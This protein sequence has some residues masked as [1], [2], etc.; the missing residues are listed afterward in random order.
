MIVFLG[1]V[2]LI[3]NELSSQYKPKY[4]Y[5]FN[6]EYVIGKKENYIPAKNKINL[7]HENSDFERIFGTNPIAV[8]VVN[9]HIFDYA[10]Q[11]Y[12]DTISKLT[13]KG[14][15]IIQT[16][17]SYIFKNIC[18]LAYM[19]LGKDTEFS[20]CKENFTSIVAEERSK[21][22][23]VR[24]VVQIHWGIENHPKQSEKQQE[25]A[26]WMI[27]QGADLIIGHHPHCIQPI[28]KYKDRY[29][30]YSLGNT[31]FGNINQPSHYDENGNPNRTYRFKW[32]KWN[33]KSLAVTYDEKNN[34]VVAVDELYQAKNELSFSKQLQLH[35]AI[36]KYPRALSKIRYI[37]RKYWLFIMSNSFIDGKLFDL[38]AIRSELRKK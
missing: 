18:M 6:L 16:K 23:D 5:V 11:G 20:V 2:A 8:S 26:H 17:P 13:Q 3:S 29:I 21:N 7:C 19:N 22:P 38:G 9:N 30:F 12:E 34:T 35:K 27:D 24:I 36:K 25:L 15:S 33:R 14:I 1:D 10:T 32:Q 31:L 28:E 4:P 37:F